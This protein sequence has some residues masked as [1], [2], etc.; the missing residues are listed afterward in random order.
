MREDRKASVIIQLSP[1][2]PLRLGLN[3]NY[4]TV[5]PMTKHL[6]AFLA[7]SLL[8]QAC[9]MRAPLPPLPERA[10]R[11]A[12]SAGV[13]TSSGREVPEER[14]TLRPSGSVSRVEI[15]TTQGDVVVFAALAHLGVR[16]RFGGNTP[17]TGFDCS[18]LV[19]YVFREAANLK[20]PRSTSE[21]ATV[22]QAIPKD[23]LRAGDLMF[24]NTLRRPNSH[25]VIYMGDG[26]F[27]HAP[28]SGG[29][30]RIEN[31]NEKYWAGRFN[32]ARRLLAQGN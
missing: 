13:P 29:A 7:I 1:N 18:G 22:G 11:T 12:P 25:V 17:E 28:S 2:L 6:F 27:V 21:I 5:P 20:L 14:I 4:V 10:A 26:R 16:Y 30:V 32:G 8:M 9:A 31:M 23:Q 24:Y 19:N 3:R 15:P